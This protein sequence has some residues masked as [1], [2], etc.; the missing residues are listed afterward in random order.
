MWLAKAGSRISELEI[1]SRLRKGM[2]M[3]LGLST[4]LLLVI[5]LHIHVSI[6]WLMDFKMVGFIFITYA[7][8]HYLRMCD[9][10]VN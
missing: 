5:S 9:L 8:L 6:Y 4:S 10:I 1:E 3:Y 7:S 2:E